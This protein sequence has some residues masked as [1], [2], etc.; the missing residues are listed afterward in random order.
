[1]LT[2]QALLSI[3]RRRQGDG[4]DKE[5]SVERAELDLLTSNSQPE[6]RLVV[7]LICRCNVDKIFRL[8]YEPV[9]ALHASFDQQLSS[10]T[11]TLSSRTLQDVIEY[12]GPKTEHVDWSEQDG[13]VIFT[14]YTEKLQ[15]GKGQHVPSSCILCN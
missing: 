6:C 7:K 10:N 14:S 1:M 15:V 9:E 4:R 13:K 3:F 8:T 12:F 11:W 5:S 2:C